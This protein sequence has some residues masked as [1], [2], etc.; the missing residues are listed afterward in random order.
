[1]PVVSW[2]PNP[3]KIGRKNPVAIVV[4]DPGPRFV[5]YPHRAILSGEHP[6]SIQIR[7]PTV[8]GVW[9]PDLAKLCHRDPGSI[10]RHGYV[11]INR[12]WGKAR[13]RDISVWK[14]IIVTNGQVEVVGAKCKRRG[15]MGRWRCKQKYG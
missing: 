10:V 6:V 1:M 11:K 12:R 8:G 15:G 4:A 13:I 7:A 3:S 9:P 14:I 5:S 2:D